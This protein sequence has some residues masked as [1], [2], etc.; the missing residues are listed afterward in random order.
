MKFVYLFSSDITMK[1]MQHF[2]F[3]L[4]VE[5]HSFLGFFDVVLL[6]EDFLGLLKILCLLLGQFRKYLLLL[7]LKAF[8]LQI[9]I[10][11]IQ[12]KELA[13]ILI[14]LTSSLIRLD[15]QTW[16]STT[17]FLYVELIL[18][19]NSLVLMLTQNT[20]H[21]HPLTLILLFS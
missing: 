7:F 21:L 19:L 15:I 8:L 2:I 13:E 10:N 4:F 12:H 11:V 3:V 20:E 1:C 14:I 16:C 6:K 18:L 17:K 5:D 9:I